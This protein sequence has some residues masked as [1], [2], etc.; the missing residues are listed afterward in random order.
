M[1]DYGEN[2]KPRIAYANRKTCLACHQ[3]EAPIFSQPPWDETQANLAIAEKL[4]TAH[5][6]A[7]QGLPTRTSQDVPREFD[8]IVER[9]NRFA[10]EQ[11]AWSRLCPSETCRT[12]VLGAMLKMR[13]LGRASIDLAKVKFDFQAR[14]KKCVA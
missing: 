11:Q 6:R 10:L 14:W 9:A 1:H 2:L 5:G 13:L 8:A 4:A 12:E 7:Y 3:N